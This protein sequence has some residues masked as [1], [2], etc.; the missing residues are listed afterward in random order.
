MEVE[1]LDVA[2]VGGVE[3][4]GLIVE[5]AGPE[6][7]WEE[8]EIVGGDLGLVFV[9]LVALVPGAAGLFVDLGGFSC[10]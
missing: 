1:V 7:A 8:G 4:D 6:V 10:L 5:V 2:E 9:D 3:G